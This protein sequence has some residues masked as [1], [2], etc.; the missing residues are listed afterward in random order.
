MTPWTVD[1]PVVRT[2]RTQNKRTQTSMPP[3]GFEPTIPVFGRTKAVQGL[4]RA[5]TA[6]GSRI[7]SRW[8]GKE[9]EGSVH[10]L[11]DI[12]FRNSFAKAEEI[13]KNLNIYN[14]CPGW[15][16][17]RVLPKYSCRTERTRVSK[18]CKLT[19]NGCNLVNRSMDEVRF[20]IREIVVLLFITSRT[21]RVLEKRRMRLVDLCVRQLCC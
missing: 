14:R 2:T 5:A 21:A 3:L 17:K 8:V 4:D 13:H 7:I 19:R 10:S 12:I 9:V 20:L 15:D 6:I 18:I 16:S 11:I 1:Q